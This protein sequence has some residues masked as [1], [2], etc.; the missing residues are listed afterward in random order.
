MNPK[1]FRR[2]QRQQLTP[3]EKSL[4]YA[5]R[6]KRFQKTKFRRQHTI[7]PYTVDFYNHPHQ[8]IIE[9]DGNGHNHLD[10]ETYDTERDTILKKQGY[11]ILRFEN[12]AILNS[13]EAILQTIENTLQQLSLGRT[14][15]ISELIE[16]LNRPTEIN[17]FS[18]GLFKF[19]TQE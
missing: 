4:W 13:L 6:A 9:L 2:Q 11:H 12:A 17:G 3:A 8:L 18:R 5:L 15:P 7:G 10:Q 1:Q 14:E 16:P 19:S